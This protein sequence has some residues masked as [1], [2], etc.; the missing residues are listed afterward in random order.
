MKIIATLLITALSFL[1]VAQLPADSRMY[2]TW[3]NQ[4]FEF[5]GSF[6]PTNPWNAEKITLKEDYTF[7]QTVGL[8]EDF[9]IDS[10]QYAGKW[11]YNEAMKK[12]RIYGDNG[13]NSAQGSIVL[14]DE[15]YTLEFQGNSYFTIRKMKGKYAVTTRFQRQGTSETF[16]EDFR[17]TQAIL[18]DRALKYDTNAVVY[19]MVNSVKPVKKKTLYFDE[20][21]FNLKHSHFNA[22]SETE[23]QESTLEGT[24]Y[25]FTDSTITLNVD[26]ETIAYSYENG[27]ESTVSNDYAYSKTVVRKELK[28]ADLDYVYFKKPR[29]Q[30]EKIAPITFSVSAITTLIVAPLISMNF[31]TGDFNKSRYYKT[32]GIGLI[33]IGASIPIAI[34][35][36][37]RPIRFIQ[38]GDETAKR[39]WYLEKVPR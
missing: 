30:G 4:G 28:I 36:K 1:S 3:I 8:V 18:A 17:K 38:L 12:L 2:G 26:Y 9:K 19:Y 21:Y 16:E 29:F 13:R 32:A 11:S 22:N 24:I 6:Y 37:E 14:F 35:F 5:E 31:K 20:A 15:E 7:T 25:D 27:S 34:I 39:N 33:G 10:F 23:K